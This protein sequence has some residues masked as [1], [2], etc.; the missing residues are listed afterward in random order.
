[1]QVHVRGPAL[2]LFQIMLFSA[3]DPI[4]SSAPL[5]DQPCCYGSYFFVISLRFVSYVNLSVYW[6]IDF[7]NA[8]R[9]QV[10]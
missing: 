3:S 7:I 6:V 2:Y 4:A 5:P 9:A 1:M 10:D 8:E